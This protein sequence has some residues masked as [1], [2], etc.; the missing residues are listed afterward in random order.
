MKKVALLALL[1]LVMSGCAERNEDGSYHAP[2]GSSEVPDYHTIVIDSCEYIEGYYRLAH[3]GNCRY[4]KER[5]K[6]ALMAVDYE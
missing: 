3:K 4:C 1:V 6:K 2:N 5:L